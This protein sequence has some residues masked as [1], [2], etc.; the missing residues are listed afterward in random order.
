[1]FWAKIHLQPDRHVFDR[2]NSRKS[3]TILHNFGS[4]SIFIYYFFPDRL[5]LKIYHVK[6]NP[7][8]KKKVA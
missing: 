8:N 4:G 7:T 2:N 6:R 5:T 1:M 3:V